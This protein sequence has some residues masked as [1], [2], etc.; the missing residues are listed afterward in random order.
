MN[1]ECALAALQ[2]VSQR[3]E[4]Q[5]EYEAEI[6][7]YQT[8]AISELYYRVTDRP[9]ENPE[10][11]IYNFCMEMAGYSS[12]DTMKKRKIN[13]FIIAYDVGISILRMIDHPRED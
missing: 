11:V 12:M 8:W 4:P 1:Q 5:N 6:F 7:A 10:D 2:E 9:F 3:K 13:P